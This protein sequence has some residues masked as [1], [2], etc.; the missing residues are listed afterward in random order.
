MKLTENN[1]HLVPVLF[2]PLSFLK[3]TV[4]FFEMFLLLVANA[5]LRQLLSEIRDIQFFSVIVD[6]ATDVA[7]NE[8]L[9]IM[10]QRVSCDYEIHKEPVG[11][12]QLPKT[13][14]ATIFEALKDVL[15]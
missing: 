7:C 8:Q 13:D 1:Y 14:P 12:V 10:I 15:L 5:V 3:L 6:E 11:L 9:S 4:H 2:K